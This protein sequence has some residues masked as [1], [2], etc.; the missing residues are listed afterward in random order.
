MNEHTA[1][2]RRL[3][4]RLAAAV[5]GS[6]DGLARTP[7][8][9]RKAVV[10]LRSSTPTSDNPTVV[11]SLV[12]FAHRLGW[13]SDSILVIEESGARLVPRIAGLALKKSSA[14]WP[15]ER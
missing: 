11:R 3:M 13:R 6:F 14:S 8:T 1:K 12:T 5:L 9:Q 15:R 4:Q 2:A 7:S 10:Y